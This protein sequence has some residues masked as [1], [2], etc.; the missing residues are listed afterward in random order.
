MCTTQFAQ[1]FEVSTAGAV[2]KRQPSVVD[3]DEVIVSCFFH[4]WFNTSAM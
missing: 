1:E 4:L 3:F 2:I